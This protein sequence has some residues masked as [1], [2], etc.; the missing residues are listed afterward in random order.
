MSAIPRYTYDDIMA[1]SWKYR[2]TEFVDAVDHVAAVEAAR[3]EGQRDALASIEALGH[4]P[5]YLTDIRKA[6]AI[7]GF[8]DVNV[9]EALKVVEGKQP[10]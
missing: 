4:S 1:G 9:E 2:L 3:A 10:T 6:L 7:K 5:L 8:S